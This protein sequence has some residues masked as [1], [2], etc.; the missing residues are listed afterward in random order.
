MPQVPTKSCSIISDGGKTE[1]SDSSSVG[2][3]PVPA[4]T[5]QDNILNPPAHLE[6]I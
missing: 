1:R 4:R 3:P 6:S 5:I 2:L